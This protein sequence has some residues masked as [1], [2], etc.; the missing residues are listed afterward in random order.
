M[1]VAF[2]LDSAG[3]VVSSHIVKSSGSSIL[4]QETLDL[5]ERA[6]PFPVPP[7]GTG[8]RDLFLEVPISYALH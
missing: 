2:V 7:T 5:F 6:Q 1:K 8:S 3:H 4:D